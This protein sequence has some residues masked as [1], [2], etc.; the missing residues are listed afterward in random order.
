MWTF[1]FLH[2]GSRDL[3]L[4]TALYPFPLLL[5]IAP[6]FSLGEPLLSHTW[7]QWSV[8]GHPYTLAFWMSMWPRPEQEW[9][10]LLSQWPQRGSSGPVGQPWSIPGLFAC[11]I[12]KERLSTCR[13]APLGE[14]SL[15]SSGHLCPHR[16]A[17]SQAERWRNSGANDIV[18]SQESSCI[19]SHPW[20]SPSKPTKMEFLSL[21]TKRPE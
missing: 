6:Q 4:L 10:V 1:K 7:P 17:L 18:C 9:R 12:S 3:L 15:N 5:Q 19:W 13:A 2:K 14:V 20:N 16:W 11:V 8:R 21:T